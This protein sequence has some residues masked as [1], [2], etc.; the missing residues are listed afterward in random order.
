MRG[1]SAKK[2]LE[3]ALTYQFKLSDINKYSKT[4]KFKDINWKIK[5]SALGKVIPDVEQRKKILFKG[6]H[7]NTLL[8]LLRA[9]D[10]S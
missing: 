2:I 3:K 7:F 5:L 9:T 4:L 1:G 8:R 6:S 10:W